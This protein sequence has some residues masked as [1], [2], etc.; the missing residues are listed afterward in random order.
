MLDSCKFQGFVANFSRYLPLSVAGPGRVDNEAPALGVFQEATGE[1]G[2]KRVRR[3]HRG[4]EVVDDQ[5]FGNAAE[6]GPGRLQPSDDVFQLL[7][8]G[9]QTKQCLE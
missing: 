2:M 9:G 1:D 7:V 6:E 5:V 8:E 4:R 3:R